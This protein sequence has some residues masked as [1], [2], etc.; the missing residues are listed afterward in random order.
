[1]GAEASAGIGCGRDARAPRQIR[2]EAGAGPPCCGH[3]H[4]RSL[5][6][7]ADRLKSC[8]S[9]GS[10]WS[11]PAPWWKSFSPRVFL[12]GPSPTPFKSFPTPWNPFADSAFVPLADTLAP[13]LEIFSPF[14]TFGES[15]LSFLQPLS[16]PSSSFV[17][18]RGFLFLAFLDNPQWFQAK[19]RA[20]SFPA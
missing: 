20:V 8:L 11:F 7:R 10:S 16:G 14:P 12:R 5:P 18:L 1:M 9:G 3:G 15:L 19:G 2:W 4:A 17:P 6:H 13:L